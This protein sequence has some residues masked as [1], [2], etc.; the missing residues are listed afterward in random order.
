MGSVTVNKHSDET[1]YSPGAIYKKI[2]R[3]D[4][5]EGI[6]WVRGPD[7]RILINQQGY[8]LWATGQL[9]TNTKASRKHQ[10]HQ[11]RSASIIKKSAVERGLRGSPPPLILEKQ[12]SSG[13]IY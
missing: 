11:S 10:K 5:K 3:G 8:E 7:N 6:V 4:W 9:T 2:Q 1:G 13:M 12:L